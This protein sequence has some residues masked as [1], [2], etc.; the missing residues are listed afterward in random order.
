[1]YKLYEND[2]EVLLERP[3][4]IINI[5]TIIKEKFDMVPY[6]TLSKC[7]KRIQNEG[8]LAKIKDDISSCRRRCTKI[9]N[10]AIYLKEKKVLEP[11]SRR[12]ISLI[13][14]GKKNKQ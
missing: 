9:I 2:Q 8:L 4:E 12:L 14:G 7:L 11:S 10:N 3:S 6:K 5:E 1:M 13:S